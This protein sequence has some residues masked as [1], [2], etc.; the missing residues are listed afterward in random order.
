MG[1]DDYL[2]M[3]FGWLR[4]R[5]VNREE[6]DRL[7]YINRHIAVTVHNALANNKIQKHS[8]MM[9]LSMDPDPNDPKRIEE[10][11]KASNE[12][13]ERAKKRGRI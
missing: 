13:F 8:D 5:K 4:A 1:P 11:R 9:P 12:L 3:Y 2:R 7:L 10:N 6:Q